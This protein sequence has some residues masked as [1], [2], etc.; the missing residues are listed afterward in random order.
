MMEILHHN[1]RV[2]NKHG[3]D[4]ADE[5]KFSTSYFSERCTI[6]K[7]L[8]A[9][10]EVILCLIILYQTIP[11]LDSPIKDKTFIKVAFIDGLV[12]YYSKCLYIV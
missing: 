6:L 11:Y 12:Q 9:I 8:S 1:P 5:T 2:L 4:F 3:Y 7:S 10:N